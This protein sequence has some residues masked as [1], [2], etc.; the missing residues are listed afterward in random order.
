MS[1]HVSARTSDGHRSPPYRH[2]AMIARQ[3]ASGAASISFRAWSSG[4][5]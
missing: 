3:S 2:R 1:A 5:K 4:T